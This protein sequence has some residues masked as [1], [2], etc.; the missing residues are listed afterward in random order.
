MLVEKLTAGTLIGTGTLS[1]THWWNKMLESALL[2]RP[3]VL[4]APM[5]TL[6]VSGGSVL[7]VNTGPGYSLGTKT[8][9]M[10][11]SER[12]AICVWVRS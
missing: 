11:L 12:T 9:L 8:P 10:Q 3:G 5:H 2:R 1:A 6:L 7:T 4:K